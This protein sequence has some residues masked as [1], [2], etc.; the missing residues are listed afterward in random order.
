MVVALLA[1]SA[2]GGAGA[3]GQAPRPSPSLPAPTASASSPA[4]TATPTC[5]VRVLDGM[6]EEQRVG[7]L[8]H[9]GLAGNRLGPAETDAIRRYH[10]GSVWF[11]VSST[12]G[13][14]GIRAVADAVQAQA[15]GDAT[16]GVR[17]LVAANQEGGQIQALQGA[18]FSRMPAAVAQGGLP[19]GD[20]E[21]DAQGWGGELRAA[22]VNMDFAPVLDVVPPGTDAG[23]QPI[24]VL[25]REYGHDPATAG[26]HGAAFLRGMQRA[27][28]V[29]TVKHFPGLGRVQGNT[30]FTAGVVD[31][32]TTPTDPYLQSFQAGIDAGAPFVM[33]ALATY[34]LIDAGQLAVFS[35]VVMRQLLRDR[36]H[37][38]GVVVSDDIGSAVAVANIPPATRAIAFLS[39]GGDMI[40]AKTASAAVAMAEAVAAKA[41]SDAGFRAR[42]ADAATRVLQA[43]QAAGLL[44]C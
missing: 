33:V 22:G 23:N 26:G 2:C 10:L 12:A 9:F 11:T 28:V 36:M 8:F 6:T 39:A 30:D 5:V 32:V 15:T 13:T 25:Q 18:G 44:P 35:P 27:G 3:S 38:Q 1:L 29:T 14:G 24:G 19:V 40:V 41:A 31:G 20:L 7:Q 16:A 21:H 37:F 34:R 42:V 4:P 43:K 17:F